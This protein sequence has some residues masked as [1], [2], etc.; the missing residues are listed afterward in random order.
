MEFVTFKLYFYKQSLK[1]FTEVKIDINDKWRHLICPLTPEMT[2]IF[3]VQ[4]LNTGHVSYCK[5][6]V[7]ANPA[8]SKFTIQHMSMSKYQALEKEA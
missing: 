1:I 4:S 5:F 2:L 3:K 6:C 8:N 7:Y